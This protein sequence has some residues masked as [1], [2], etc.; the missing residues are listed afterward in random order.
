[1]TAVLLAL[2]LGGPNGSGRSPG[3][4]GP[5][6]V[7]PSGAIGHDISWPQCE[8]DRP[9]PAAFGVVGVTGGRSY[10]RNPCLAGQFA[11]AEAT[12]G[13]AAFYMNT[14]NPGADAEALDWYAQ[15]S[16]DPACGPAGEGA[17]AYDFGFNAAADAF[18]YA[19]A[20]TGSAAGR[21]WWLDVEPDNSWSDNVFA[22]R[23]SLQGSIDFLQRQP[24]VVVG[25]Y[26]TPRMWGR[27]MGDHRLALPNWTAGSTTLAEAVVRCAPV[28]SATGGPVV[29]S[30]WVEG[31][32]N[33]YVC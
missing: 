1:M 21:V 13:G 18:T 9:A 24:G 28:F 20:A 26:S 11:W 30:Q 14:S 8:T 4:G 32:D 16:P 17:C 15:R 3:P 22:N 23:A 10:T 29:L 12:P 25:V 6:R 33:D 7:I 2:T 19:Q 31:F 27:I 5:P